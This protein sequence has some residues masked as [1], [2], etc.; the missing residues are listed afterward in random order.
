MINR[1][2]D[3]SAKLVIRMEGKS[4]FITDPRLMCKCSSESY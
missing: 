4:T 1:E 3:R 2:K